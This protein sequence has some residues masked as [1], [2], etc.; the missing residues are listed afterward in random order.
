MLPFLD[1]GQQNSAAVFEDFVRVNSEQLKESGG[2]C[3]HGTRLWC[4]ARLNSP[5]HL[6]ERY[7][8][9]KYFLQ[10]QLS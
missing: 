6:F 9:L 5:E 7:M 4:T 1:E 3:M 2:T 8:A 10:G